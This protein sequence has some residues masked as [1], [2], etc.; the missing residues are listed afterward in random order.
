MKVKDEPRVFALSSYDN[1]I[2]LNISTGIIED[3]S[4][5]RFR[6]MEADS[7]IVFLNI[8]GVQSGSLI[9]LGRSTKGQVWPLASM[10]NDPVLRPHIKVKALR[11]TMLTKPRSGY[12][13]PLIR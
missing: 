7:N 2:S 3:M 11:L 5:G 8:L 12:V 6:L 9:A 4:L 13:H 1:I 10:V